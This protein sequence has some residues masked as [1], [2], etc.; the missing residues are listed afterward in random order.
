[1]T[2]NELSYLIRG[3]IFDVRNKLGPGLLESVYISALV[4]ELNQLG[5]II[6]TEASL[7]FTY[8]GIKMT[9]AY[10]IDILVNEKVIIEV[11]SLEALSEVHH[12]QVLTYLKLSNLKLAILVNFGA[13]DISKEIFRKVNKL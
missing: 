8:N 6:K 5:L 13:A 12:K 10:R 1:M 7:P 11:K 4:N 9:N 2:E 3:A